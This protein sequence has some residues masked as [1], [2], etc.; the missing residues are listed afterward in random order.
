[1]RNLFILIFFCIPLLACS[2]NNGN[3]KDKYADY[4]LIGATINQEDYQ[5][6]D[7]DEKVLKIVSENFNSLTPE[8]SMKWMHAHPEYSKFTFSNAQK[9]TDFAKDN[10]MYLLGHTLVWHNQVP[11]Y[12]SEI[13]D[14]GKFNLHLKNHIFQ[15]VT[16]FKGKVN[17][18][19]VVNEALNDDGT[20]RET[21]FL[22][23]M[24]DDYIDKAFQYANDSDPNVELAYNDYNLYKPKKR[25]GA[26]RIINSL[27]DKGIRIDAVGIQAHWD[28]HFPSIQEI[29]KTIIELA[30]TGVDVMITE[31]DITVIPNPYELAGIAR[32]EFKKFEGDK[33]WDPYQ[34]GIPENVQK[35]LTKRYKDIFELFVK[36]HDK[37]SRVTFWGTTDKYTWRNQNPINNRADYP[38]LFDREYKK[39]P[40]YYGLL[41]I[42][43]KEKK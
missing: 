34:S 43:L 19:D 32:E 4:F 40:A 3:L 12:I 20:L 18:W 29:E 15:L 30:A 6:I 10:D 25:A 36:H 38:L 2:Q 17:M 13:N 22:N 27:K 8:N 16:R 42:D 7:K 33:K 26:I 24:G 35:K 11:E 39:K 28:L 23:M 9:I 5:I 41:D 37:I 31:L 21:V 14:R 1:M